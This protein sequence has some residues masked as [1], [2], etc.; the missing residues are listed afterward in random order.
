MATAQGTENYFQRLAH[1]SIPDHAMRTLGQT[2]FKVSSIGFGGYRIHHDSIEHA[3]ALRYALLNGFNLIDTSSNYGDGGSEILIGNLIQEMFSRNEL[4]RD[5]IVIVSK[6]GY[7]QGENM[8]LA[9]EN[10]AGGQ[11]FPDLVKFMEN[12]WHCIHPDFLQD[13]LIRSLER[14]QLPALDVYLLHN[15]EYYLSDA[16]K[17]GMDLVEARDEYY[18]RIKIAFEWL[19]EKV[20]EGKIKAYGISS[21]TFPAPADNFEFT[22]L[23]QVLQIAASIASDHYFQIIQF[24]FNLFETGAVFEK[25]QDNGTKTLLQLAAE[26][27]MATLV[28]R[29]LNAMKNGAMVRLASFRETDPDEIKTEFA[30]R[31][32]ELSEL[33]AFFRDKL[34]SRCPDEIPAENL[35]QVFSISQQLEQGLHFFRNW[36]HWDHVKQN[37]IMPQSYTYLSF[38]NQKLREDT[39]WKE[40]SDAYAR[41]LFNFLGI[42]SRQYENQAQKRSQKISEK[43]EALAPALHK[44]ETLSQKSLQTLASIAGIGCVLL[45]MRRTPYVED[46]F[47]ALKAPPLSSAETVLAN[48]NQDGV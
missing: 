31:L 10:E 1:K 4:T 32:S 6:A 40:W 37:V 2:G 24:P 23:E 18:R 22:S 20:A 16:Q 27:N 42:I 9:R 8:K 48:L 35:E 15:P 5:E 30:Q 36:E 26:K 14:L 43:L 34:I 29:P 41:T 44:T 28:N 33:E 38:L 45:G 19:E 11:P 25:N 47:A 39:E 17:N 21:N 46:A 13:Q 12:C 3:K 7:V